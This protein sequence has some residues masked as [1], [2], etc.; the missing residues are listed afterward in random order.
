[1]AA[2]VQLFITCLV[3]SFFPHIGEAMLHVL[4][5]AGVQV[6]FPNAQTC[7]GQ[8]AF[9]AGLRA[10]ARPLAMHTIEVFE[11]TSGDIIIPSGSC[12][13]MVRQGYPE[14]FQDDP[15]WLMRA[16][17][18]AQRTYE[19]SE[20][21]VDVRAVTDLSACWKGKIAYHPACHLL[22]SLGVDRQPRALLAAVREA[23][24]VELPEREDC[25][26]F[27]GVFSVEHPEL[28]AEFLKRKLAN[29]ERTDA[30]TLV[31]ADTGCLMHLQ[32]GLKR[33]GKS[34]R[35]VHLAEVLNSR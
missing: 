10:E 35:V 17:A 28:S 27:G 26:G 22:C 20:Y 18:L 32:G 15:A 5:R 7:C 8:P 11:K 24:I 33:Q 4:N 6:E 23:E 21:L 3:D 34:Q 14:L 9:N 2:T 29:F 1:M 16:E 19:F 13:A 12:A 30:P 25:C 31:V